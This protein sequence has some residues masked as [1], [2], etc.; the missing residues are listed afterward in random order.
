MTGQGDVVRNAAVSVPLRID[1]H[2][3][4]AAAPWDDYLRGLV[5]QVLM[6]APGERVNRPD[7]GAGAGQLLFSPIGP[8]VAAT[9]QLLIHGALQQ[10]VADVVDVLDVAVVAD[11]ATLVV[12]VTYA[13]RGT[14][15]ARTARI[16]VPGV[17]P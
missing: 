13:A 4:T 16:S 15:V 5:T 11:D 1:A 12:D 2:G 8:E 17:T 14:G 10:W 9:A 6:T 3:A 7:F